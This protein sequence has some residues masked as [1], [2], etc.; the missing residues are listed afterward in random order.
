MKNLNKAKYQVMRDLTKSEYEEL[1]N[2][3][4]E[5]GVLVAIAVDEN[6]DIID[7]HHRKKI[8]DELGVKDYPTT[9]HAG[10]SDGEK[11]KMA[12]QMNEAR[13]QLTPE[14]KRQMAE[15]RLKETPELSDRQIAKQIGASQPFVSSVRKEMEQSGDVITVITSTDTLGREQPRPIQIETK[16][17]TICGQKKPTEEFYNGQ[18]ICKPCHNAK[19][20]KV[21]RDLKGNIIRSNPEA[22]RLFR[23]NA[24]LLN[25]CADGGGTAGYSF[26]DLESEVRCIVSYFTR[27]A[28]TH[29]A[30]HRDLVSCGEN[31]Q[32]L[33]AVL[34]D[35]GTAV[36]KIREEYLS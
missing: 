11:T 19:K 10:L 8:C 29:I 4:T 5:K 14:E 27:N 2:S 31:K 16:T 15:K 21:Y 26:D 36:E 32:R 18:G 7:G 23:E 25:P 12:K 6:G 1:K 30:E 20:P 22:D 13:R 9:V 3:I 24:G 17:C 34:S 28:R 33:I 35:A